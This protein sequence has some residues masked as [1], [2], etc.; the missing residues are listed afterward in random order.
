MTI[1]EMLGEIDAEKIA[2][3]LADDFISD[4]IVKGRIDRNDLIYNFKLAIREMQNLPSW[5]NEDGEIVVLKI[6][7][8][9][10]ENESEKFEVLCKHPNDGERYGIE[11]T[12][13]RKLIDLKIADL[14]FAKYSINDIAKVILHSMTFMGITEKFHKEKVNEE[15]KILTE[16]NNK[17]MSEGAIPFDEYIKSLGF[18]PRKETEEEKKMRYNRMQKA[19][20]AN[21]KVYEE[22]GFSP[23]PI[24]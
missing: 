19:V 23:I 1:R 18:E 13:W 17:E 3:E 4:V 10:I 21:N 8:Y 22:F 2:A 20:I 7:D 11:M 15:I 6:V 9:D 24:D 12:P 5:K 14:S 16:R